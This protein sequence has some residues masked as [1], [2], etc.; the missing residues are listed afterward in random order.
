[1]L[2]ILILRRNEPVE[3]IENAFIVILSGWIYWTFPSLVTR[4]MMHFCY[5]LGTSLVFMIGIRELVNEYLSSNK[6]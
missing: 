5:F 1:M 4:F 2:E 6:E 3:L